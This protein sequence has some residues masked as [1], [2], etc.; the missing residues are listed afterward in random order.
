MNYLH[1]KIRNYLPL[2]IIM[3]GASVVLAQGFD[4]RL[5]TSQSDNFS[6]FTGRVLERIFD[7]HGQGLTLTAVPASDRLPH[8]F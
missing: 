6:Q 5:G 3:W 8:A 1:V 4:I 2:I 7:R